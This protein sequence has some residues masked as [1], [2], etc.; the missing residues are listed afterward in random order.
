ME[1][2]NDR[3]RAAIDDPVLWR[4]IRPDGRLATMPRRSAHRAQL[5]A[6]LAERFEPERDYGEAEVNRVLEAFHDDFAT[7]RRYLVDHGLLTRE[8]ERY[9]RA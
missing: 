2:G 8:R 1:R 4:Y 7:L 9:R 5:L 6:W 3:K